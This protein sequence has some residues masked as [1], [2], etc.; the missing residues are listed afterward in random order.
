MTPARVLPLE[1][2]SDVCEHLSAPDLARLERVNRALGRCARQP[3]L[4]LL[5]GRLVA[6]CLPNLPAPSPTGSQEAPLARPWPTPAAVQAA[7]TQ[8]LAQ[9]GPSFGARDAAWA[10]D[11]AV[12]GCPWWQ[13]EGPRVYGGGF[14]GPLTRALLAACGPFADLHA[15]AATLLTDA[16]GLEALR[17]TPLGHAI[18]RA[19]GEPTHDATLRPTL[20]AAVSQS[21][22]CTAFALRLQRGVGLRSVRAYVEGRTLADRSLERLAFGLC[23]ARGRTVNEVPEDLAAPD[24]LATWRAWL[25]E[26]TLPQRAAV[27]ALAASPVLVDLFADATAPA[28][29]NVAPHVTAHICASEAQLRVVV[30]YAA[31]TVASGVARAAQPLSEVQGCTLQFFAEA[32]TGRAPGLCDSLVDSLLP[33]LAASL[34]A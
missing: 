4:P 17:V 34:P 26:H 6:F 15:F 14:A 10:I 2:W 30:A 27:S 13:T 5:R 8:H 28:V 7:W 21:L 23:V 29:P 12:A 16:W 11:W 32:L 3:A 33:S 1:L 31:D 20:L 19:L 9:V 18:L 22:L 24:P 25:D